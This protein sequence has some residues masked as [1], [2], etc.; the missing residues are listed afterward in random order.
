[1]I[2][3]KIQNLA[4]DRKYLGK[5]LVRGLE[6]LA[7]TDFSAMAAGRYEIEGAAMFALV[8]EYRTAPKAEKK[9][10]A[11]R[12]YID[13]QYIHQGIEI[14]GFGLDDPANEIS[15]DRLAEKD[16]LNFKGIRNETDLVLTPGSYAI[17]FPQD[18]HRPGCDFG[19]G[20]TVKKVVLKISMDLL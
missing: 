14:M 9:P 15:A 19:A 7:G 3:G 17:L 12:K 18:V 1:M 11:H 2:V 20:G 10:E 16:A 8:Q 6:Y 5:A 4:A 13:I